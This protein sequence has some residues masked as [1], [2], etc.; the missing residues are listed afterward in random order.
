MRT[1]VQER[2]R[3]PEDRAVCPVLARPAKIAI[4]DE[5]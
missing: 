5:A 2:P 3:E 1:M 4:A